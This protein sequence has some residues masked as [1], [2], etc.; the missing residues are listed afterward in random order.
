MK[1]RQGKYDDAFDALAK[2]AK[3]DPKNAEIQ[4]HLGLVLSQ[5]GMRKEAETALRK[6]IELDPNY[7]SAHNN[8]AVV[9]ITQKPPS[10]ALA[11]WHYD[12]A[13]SL[14]MPANPQLEKMLDANSPVSGSA[15]QP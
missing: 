5:K 2:A 10:A 13:R 7:A 9:Y 4:N 8:L 6:A 3:L 12:K 11:R 15:T 14:G 1:F